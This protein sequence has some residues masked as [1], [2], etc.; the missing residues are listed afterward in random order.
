MARKFTPQV[1]SANHLIEGDT[2]W[3]DGSDW[4]RDITRARAAE[5]AEEAEALLAQAQAGAEAHRAVGLYLAE[6][7]IEPQGPRPTHFREIYRVNG[8]KTNPPHE[9]HI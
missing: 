1:V 9:E 6:V 2:I 5:T 3:F 7:A 4:V 8:H